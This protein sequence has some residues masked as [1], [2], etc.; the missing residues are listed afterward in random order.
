MVRNLQDLKKGINEI[1][2]EN[3]EIELFENVNL[4]V[5]KEKNSAEEEN[6]QVD[7]KERKNLITTLK[8]TSSNAEKL[9]DKQAKVLEIKNN[10]VC[11]D[12]QQVIYG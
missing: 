12:I 3:E 6:L 9:F 4:H 8:N 10:I 2:N 1:L 5:E 11:D 7:F